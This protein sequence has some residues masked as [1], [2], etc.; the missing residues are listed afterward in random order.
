M[1]MMPSRKIASYN[2]GKMPDSHKSTEG[3]NNKGYRPFLSGS[4]K[5]NRMFLQNKGMVKNIIEPPLPIG[6][7]NEYALNIR[8][9]QKVKSYTIFR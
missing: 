2:I 6:K 8:Y 9:F 3:P 4:F 1:K 5:I 7:E